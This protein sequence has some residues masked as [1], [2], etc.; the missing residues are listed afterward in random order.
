MEIVLGFAIFFEI[1]I[2]LAFAHVIGRI[3]RRE[4]WR[5]YC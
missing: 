1:V 3:N 4:K 2:V 5:D